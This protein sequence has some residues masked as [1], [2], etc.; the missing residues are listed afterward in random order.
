MATL[1]LSRPA[2]ERE[3]SRGARARAVEAV[4]GEDARAKRGR[5]R[6]LL[7]LL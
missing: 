3:A 4:S 5:P 2:R 6:P 1:V 7:R